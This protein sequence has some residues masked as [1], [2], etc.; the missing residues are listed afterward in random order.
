MAG[1]RAAAAL[2]VALAL[3]ACATN[4]ACRQGLAVRSFPDGAPLMRVTL[5]EG[6]RFALSFRHSVTLR[7]IEERYVVEG[8]RIVQTAML[9]D[10]HGPGLPDRAE[11]GLRW[12][13]EGDR[14]AVA[15]ERPIERL[16]VR[17]APAHDNRLMARRAI[18]LTQWG[19]RAV[20]IA[21]LACLD[22]T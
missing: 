4:N 2:A 12:G 5:E 14:F 20:E 18:D 6:D 3:A 17:V 19:S 11:P 7:P 15:M 21:P 8:G 1:P 10:Q 16:V 9:F 13:R 22:P